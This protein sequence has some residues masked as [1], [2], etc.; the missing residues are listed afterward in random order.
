MNVV[1]GSTNIFDVGVHLTAVVGVPLLLIACYICQTRQQID[2]PQSAGTSHFLVA[3]SL[4]WTGVILT[5]TLIPGS[6]SSTSLQLV[7]LQSVDT[8]DP[9]N[10]VGNLLLF[11][12]LGLLGGTLGRPRRVVNRLVIGIAFSICIEI[13]QF[14]FVSGR[15]ASVTDVLLNTGGMGA[16]LMAAAILGKIASARNLSVPS[17]GNETRSR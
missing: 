16:G 4:V 17:S 15:T 13:A 3:L 12:P 6:G 1:F 7:P 5:M 10:L 9:I 11:F 8:T 2:I 14:L